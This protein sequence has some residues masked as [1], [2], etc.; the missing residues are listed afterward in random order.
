MQAAIQAFANQVELTEVDAS[1]VLSKALS[2]YEGTVASGGNRYN[3]NVVGMWEFKTGSGTVA[4]DTSG[5][6]P[7]IDLARAT[8]LAGG[9]A[10]PA[11]RRIVDHDQPKS[12]PDRYGRV[13]IAP[14]ARHRRRKSRESCRT[15]R[16]LARGFIGQTLQLRSQPPLSSTDRDRL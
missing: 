11:A 8:C 7:A 16:R 12:R 4:Y 9:W 15:G 6:E 5:V 14:A 10:K 1:L 13:T 3:G 2:L